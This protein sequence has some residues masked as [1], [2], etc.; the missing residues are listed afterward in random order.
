MKKQVFAVFIITAMLLSLVPVSFAGQEPAT[1]PVRFA[2][3]TE[4]AEDLTG[5]TITFLHFGDL[6][7]AYAFITQPL[8]AG[9]SDAIEYMNN[10][11]GGL[12]G[13][14][15]AQEFR[16]TGGAQEQT[17]AFWDEFSERDD[18]H[19]IFLYASADGELLREQAAEKGIVL[20]NAA[21]SE[22][23]LYGEDGEAGWQ[24]S[25][26]PLYTNQLGAFCDYVA[27]SWDMMGMEGEP[28]IGHLSWE[29][30][31]GR[32]SDTETTRAYC[33]S[34][35]I[36]YAGAEYFAPGTPD[37][38]AQLQTLVE[39]GA[40]IIYTTSL[41]SGPA[42]V[43][44]TID[45]LGL[46]GSV[47]KAG[48][49]WALD[50]S[51]VGLGGASTIGITGNVPYY[52]WDETDHPGVQVVEQYWTANRLATADDPIDAFRVRN[53]AYLSTF[54]TLDMWGEVM[55]QTINRVGYENLSGAD[56]YET[57]QNLVYD[58]FF[59]MIQIDFTNGER[60]I[61]NTRI[62]AIQ[63]IETEAGA[64]PGVLATTDFVEAPDL[65]AGMFES[66]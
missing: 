40:N 5:E 38:S 35:G 23:A 63:I 45:T 55:V 56:V 49:N 33:E 12:C 19:V 64:N 15:I 52:W 8:L 59:G 26:I 66:E 57:M 13:A 3:E 9:F 36:G 37:I 60:A 44:G 41:A 20:I 18:A 24:F 42:Q 30:A 58:P 61:K 29:G 32:S 22:L 51:V 39:N 14:T 7:G 47:M 54:P 50:T 53:I 31:F 34:K 4:C 25:I 48:V 27:E 21:A 17:Q 65:R 46:T 6:S 28:T 62:G 1:D 11:Q 2:I 16:D 43:A 10:E